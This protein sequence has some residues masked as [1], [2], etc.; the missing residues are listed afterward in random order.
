MIQNINIQFLFIM[1]ILFIIMY[2]KNKKILNMQIEKM[3]GSTFSVLSL[4]IEDFFLSISAGAVLTFLFNFFEIRFS[5]LKEVF[6]V[7]AISI[8]LY[9]IKH[10]FICFS[11][12]VSLFSLF[13]IFFI[14]PYFPAADFILFVAL[15]HIV[16]GILVMIDGHKAA[17]PFIKEDAGKTFGG[18]TLKR[19]YTV[20]FIIMVLNMG[21]IA[22]ASMFF[23]IYSLL[24]YSSVTY[25]MSKRV[26]S[27][28]S[29]MLIMFYGLILYGLTFILNTDIKII[30]LLLI[31][32]CLHEIMLMLNRK[33]E[34]KN[35]LKFISDEN[36]VMV[37]EVCRGFEADKN[38]IKSG[39]K[40]LD[41]CGHKVRN[42]EEINSLLE[43][44][45]I[46]NIKVMN[47]KHVI[48]D[49]NYKHTKGMKTGMMIIP[50]RDDRFSTIL[51]KMAEKN[52]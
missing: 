11:Y 51:N 4:T 25:T 42:E 39:F 29:G 43:S 28:Y 49:I 9:K 18:F 7:F 2:K 46:S 22:A 1:C 38:G 26:K 3:G 37:L 35:S 8:V 31:M 45:E 40:I 34:Q 12:S 23:T 20:P 47:S 24:G 32:P 50:Y 44:R 10:H 15:L 17:V 13:S 21:S 33:I 6:I 36:G 48:K 52:K 5:D 16:E 14:D 19:Y 30:I 27:L 41:I